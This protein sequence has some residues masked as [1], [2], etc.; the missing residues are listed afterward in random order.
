MGFFEN[1]FPFFVVYLIWKVIARAQRG[2]P[3]KGGS[4]QDL[5]P[6]VPTG[7]AGQPAGGVGELLRLLV[8]QARQP[9]GISAAGNEPAEASPPPPRTG[10]PPGREILPLPRP[11]RREPQPAPEAESPSLPAVRAAAPLRPSRRQLRQAVL[12]TEIL[13]RPVGLRDQSEASAAGLPPWRC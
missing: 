1:I 11:G 5:A 4:G 10:D 6:Q 8:E 7:R 12:W 2:V 9:V 13:G 3:G